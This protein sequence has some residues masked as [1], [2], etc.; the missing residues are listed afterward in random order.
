ML[1]TYITEKVKGRL[2]RTRGFF[3]NSIESGFCKTQVLETRGITMQ[4][5]IKTAKMVNFMLC[6]FPMIL[7]RSKSTYL[8]SSNLLKYC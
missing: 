3:L 7:K 8:H 6:M 2:W 5:H 1:L 4:I